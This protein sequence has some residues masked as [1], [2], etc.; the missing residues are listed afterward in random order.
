MLLFQ[1]C[2]SDNSSDSN[3]PDNSVVLL[4]TVITTSIVGSNQRVEAFN[5]FYNGTKIDYINFSITGYGASIEG[6]VVYTYSGNLISKYEIFDA[7]NVLDSKFTF[8]YNNS[9]QVIERSKF[10]YGNNPY[11]QIK[12]VFTYNSDGTITRL[13]YEA[14]TNTPLNLVA[15]YT[16]TLQNNEI[17]TE[18]TAN[19]SGLINKST[20]YFYDTKN[21]PIKNVIGGNVL[22]TTA[23]RINSNNNL[24]QEIINYSNTTTTENFSITY[25]SNNYPISRT[26]STGNLSQTYSYY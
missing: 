12:D 8:T 1:S 13:S 2:S 21:N 6:K 25:N 14:S 20:Q 22:S 15:N 9:Q 17:K 26:S 11:L 10:K 4:K 7:N 18:V 24:T 5:Y 19:P 23:P 16:Y 3:N